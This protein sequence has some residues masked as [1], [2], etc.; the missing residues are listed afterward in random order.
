M[1]AGPGKSAKPDSDENVAEGRASLRR[2]RTPETI[3]D[4]IG[5]RESF[6]APSH[7]GPDDHRLISALTL[8][9]VVGPP[10]GALDPSGF[11]FSPD[12]EHVAYLHAHLPHD[13]AS[14][15]TTWTLVVLDVASGTRHACFDPSSTPVSARGA[16]GTDVSREHAGGV[17]VTRYEWASEATNP[18]RLLVPRPEGAYVVDVEK[19]PREKKKKM[20][21][22]RRATIARVFRRRVSRIPGAWRAPRATRRFLTRAYL[23]MGAGSRSCAARR[24]TSRRATFV[25]KTRPRSSESRTARAGARS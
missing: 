18:S 1:G 8:D 13:P 10:P 17:G 3:G 12:N 5:A 6:P 23:P 16:G 4:D 24:S 9:D 25:S 15:W 20:T 19:S 7:A 14:A 2:D 21:S 11:E 22:R